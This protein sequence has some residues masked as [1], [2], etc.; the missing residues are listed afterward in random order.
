MEYLRGLLGEEY[1]ST[2]QN[3]LNSSL[4]AAGLQGL[5]ASGP[6]LMPTSAGQ[7]LGQAGMAGVQAY[8]GAMDQAEKQGIRSMELN[9]VLREKMRMML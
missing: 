4:L 2:K 8:G 7:I 6:S 3:A 1:E 5:M 9:E